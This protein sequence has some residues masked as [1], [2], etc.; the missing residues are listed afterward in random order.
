MMNTAHSWGSCGHSTCNAT[1][2]GV[3]AALALALVLL[4][5]WQAFDSAAMRTAWR[6]GSSDTDIMR[7]AEE[8]TVDNLMAVI[9][10]GANVNAKSDAGAWTPLMRAA[11]CGNDE[12]CRAL[13]ARGAEVN[14]TTSFGW[15]PLMFVALTGRDATARTILR[16]G[17]D[18]N[19]A[20]PQGR[21]TA[22][23]VATR[24]GNRRIA[25]DLIA[26]GA[27][28]DATDATGRTLLHFAADCPDPIAASTLIGD[29]LS[30]GLDLDARDSAGTTPLM[31]AATAGNVEIVELLLR[32]GSDPEARNSA[33][34]TA[35]DLAMQNGNDEVARLLELAIPASRIAFSSHQ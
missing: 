8:E 22:L 9:A 4:V 15:T 26:A 6:D 23:K 27:R 3:L 2:R 1:I 34:E 29:L 11:V 16:A 18:V 12:C 10:R 5:S 19:F 32:A 28:L 21:I 24:E 31:E 14:A 7:A 30:R 13:L 25:H 17:A 33:H 35:L 20:T